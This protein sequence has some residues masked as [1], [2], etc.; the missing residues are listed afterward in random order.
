MDN[1][2]RYQK[3]VDELIRKS[4]PKLMGKKII[5]E[6]NSLKMGSMRASRGLFRYKIIID[7][8]KY[9]DANPH[10]IRG[11]FAHELMHFEYYAS[12]NYLA[13]LFYIIHYLLSKQFMLKEEIENDKRTIKRGYGR[14]LI[15]N[16]KYR[17]KGINL[18]NIKF[19]PYMLPNEIK[20][21]MNKK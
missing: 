10:Q 12:R 1:V 7:A 5:I 13:Y 19:R 6:L 16:R 3:I 18:K 4:F 2:K 21:Y 15:E 14:D 17:L 20:Q 8:D 11:A 9:K